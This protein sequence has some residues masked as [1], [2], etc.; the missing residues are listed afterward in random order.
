MAV[1]ISAMV[2]SVMVS[3]VGFSFGLLVEVIELAARNWAS[4]ERLG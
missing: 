4:R 1:S 2:L 3:I